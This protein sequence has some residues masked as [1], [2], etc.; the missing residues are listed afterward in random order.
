VSCTLEQ[1]EYFADD[2]QSSVNSRATAREWKVELE[3]VETV[4]QDIRYFQRRMGH[5]ESA[6]NLN[7]E[8]LGTSRTNTES[9][10]SLPLV[11]RDVQ[12]DFLALTERMTLLRAR[13]DNLAGTAHEVTSLNAAFRG[14]DDSA[15]G[16]RLSVFAAVIFPLTLIAS[17]LS[18]GGDFAPGRSHFWIFFAS[19]VPL[20]LAFGAFLK[21]GDYLLVFSAD[22]WKAR[23]NL[24]KSQS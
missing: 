22:H 7:L 1:C 10:T 21:W 17:I 18:M 11:L 16:L 14:I 4:A 2:F 9:N 12:K 13:L 6:M 19:A 8:R 3:R 15:F 24:N 20:S 23:K 5:F